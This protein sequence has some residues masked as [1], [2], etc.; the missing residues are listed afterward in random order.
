MRQKIITLILILAAI[1]ALPARGALYIVGDA[2]FGG[3]NPS[4]GMAMTTENEVVYMAA[5]VEISGTVY[6]VFATELGDW[7][8]VNSNRYGPT[9]GDQAV[10]VDTEITTQ[11][12][13]NDQAAYYVTGNGSYNIVMDIEKLT[14]TVEEVDADPDGTQ[15]WILGNAFGGS[16]DPSA[17]V[18]M[19]TKD[20]NVFTATVEMPGSENRFSFTTMLSENGNWDEIKNYRYGSPSSSYNINSLLGTDIPLKKST[21]S[22][23]VGQGTYVIT[24]NLSALTMKVEKD[25]EPVEIADVWVLGEV[26][27]NKWDPSVG[28]KMKTDNGITYTATVTTAGENS[29][30]SYFSFTKKLSESSSDWSAIASERFGAVSDG[31]FLVGQK[32]L[33]KPLSLTMD[34]KSFQI[35]AG[36]YALQLNLSEMTL[37]I[38]GHAIDV[39]DADRAKCFIDDP[40]NRTV[41]F[42]FDPAL[43]KYSGVI[44]TAYVRGSFTGWGNYDYCKMLYDPDGFYYLTLP[45]EQVKIPGN[46][47]QPEFKFYINGS[48][49]GGDKS[50]VPEGYIFMNGDQNH[51]V[52]FAD[53]DFEQIKANS[54]TANTVRAVSDFDLTTEAGQMEVSNF[55]RVPGT[56]QLYRCY[57]PFKVSRAGYASE[58]P[59]MQYVQ[60]LS[61]RFGILSDIVLSG[62]ETGSLTTVTI[63]GQSYTERIPEYYQAIID[64]NSV[65][66]VGKSNSTPDYNTVYYKPESD[67]FG[68]WMSEVAAFI[69]DDNNSAPFSIHCR[70]GTDRTGVFSAMLAA[71]CGAT[72]QEIAADYQLTNRLG[73][74]EFRDY[75]LLQYAMQRMLGVEDINQVADLQA[76]VVSYFVDNNYISAEQIA[77]I[78]RKLAGVPGDLNGDGNV[79]AGDVSELYDLI[80]S[81]SL[82]PKGDLNDDGQVN[83]GDVSELYE[84][85]LRQ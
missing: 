60:E 45:Y 77:V 74:K 15:M 40:E 37:T 65:L 51:I 55:R 59:R 41:T 36:E 27:G 58:L 47:G 80:L 84:L 17:G 11:L 82:D 39:S 10:A 61:A 33:N 46:S 35:E 14:F 79:N 68:T 56:R 83:A 38:S 42:I 24:V 2:P 53:D 66:Y 75:H 72:W 6:F 32:Y 44:N 34:G 7:S 71:I 4:A 19:K 49:P 1:V 3:W 54:R 69:A 52:V 57:H 64:R 29:G 67:K 22:F 13:G 5:N 31:N 48:Y 21:S 20:H 18:K 12:S 28:V 76:A 30:Y 62:D 50:F 23:L 70:L 43:W 85:I 25:G 73:I 63:A 16:F 26:N 81:G 9:D 8:A 78:Q